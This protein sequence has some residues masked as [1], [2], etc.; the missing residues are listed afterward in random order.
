MHNNNSSLVGMTNN[1]LCLGEKG[2]VDEFF[3][4]TYELENNGSDCI[5]K[6]L[7]F[8][9][10]DD[11]RSLINRSSLKSIVVLQCMRYKVFI[12]YNFG[13]KSTLSRVGGDL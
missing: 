4:A 2:E 10:W 5:S 12:N 1:G 11:G 3:A 6:D 7:S 9:E 13:W 8:G